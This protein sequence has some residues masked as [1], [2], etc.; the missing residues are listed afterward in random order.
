MKLTKV[1]T[2]VVVAAALS[3]ASCKPKDADIKEK[4]DAAIKANPMM[5]GAVADVK[6]GVV[7]ITGEMKDSACKALCN[8]AFKDIK[9]IDHVVNNAT[10]TPPPPPPV[11]ASVTSTLDDAA[12]QKVKDGL[13]DFTGVTVTFEGDKAVL[14]GEV[15]AK[16]R[17]TIMQ[18]LAS[19]KVK[20]DVTKLVDKK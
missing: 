4:V 2:G 6:D 17:M 1:M 10:V 18:M 15:T 20:S 5:S 9:G 16:Q 7:T 12:M 14:A 19:A 11:P 3:F 8:D 13:K